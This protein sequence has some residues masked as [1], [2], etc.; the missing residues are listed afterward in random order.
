MKKKLKF[1]LTMCFAIFLFSILTVSASAESTPYEPNRTSS[2]RYLYSSSDCDRTITVNCYDRDTGT[3]IKVVNLRTK[4]SE[5]TLA[6]VRIYGYRLT[7][8]SSDQGLWETCK[9]GNSQGLQI[10]GEI[11]IKYYF[12]TAMS[13]EKLT[14]T[15]YMDKF[16][17]LTLT[18]QHKKQE[19]Y[20]ANL[21]YASYP[22]TYSR[23]ITTNTGRYVSMGGAYTGFTIRSGWE[24]YVAGNFSYK[25][26][27]DYK[28]I[29]SPISSM[30]WRVVGATCDTGAFYNEFNENE[31]GHYSYCDNRTMVC[32]FEYLRNKYTVSFSANGGTG[33]VPSS[34]TQY[35]GYTVT[36]GT[37]VP[38]RDGY[39]FKGWSTS[40]SATAASY[41]PGGIYTMGVT[42]TLYAVWEKY[43]YEFSISDLTVTL[44][45]ELFP[46]TTIPIRVRTDSW[47]KNDSYDDVPVELYYDGKLLSTQYID[48]APFQI[49]Y[50][51]FNLNVG[52]STGSHTIEI[53]INWNKKSAETNP[54]NN[55]VKTEI[56]I[57][58][59]SYGF[60]IQAL[61][62]SARYKEGT[63]VMTSFIVYN[64]SERMVLPD[65]NASAEFIVYYYDGNEKVLLTNQVWYDIVIPA[66]ESNLI[67]FR[68]TVPEDF[69]GKNVVCQC[70]INL[71]GRLKEGN[72]LDNVVT[73]TTVIADRGYSQTSN[74]SYEAKAPGDYYQATAPSI[75]NG[76]ASWSL[77]EYTN[78]E[79]VKVQYG[80]KISGDTPS[81]QP[82]STCETAIYENGSWT[83]KSGY[84]ITLTYAPTITSLSGSQMPSSSDYTGI[85]TVYAT[86]PE[87]CYSTDPEEFRSLESVGGVW[88]FEENI[89]ADGNERLHYIPVWMEDG[90]YRVSVTV[91]D[92]WTPAGLVMSVRNSEIIVVDGTIFD[93][94]YIGI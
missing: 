8:F 11:Y 58:S 56:N 34:Q 52:S 42:P 61:T 46:N 60:E 47:D 85:Q 75:K 20:G 67:F 1:L 17:D 83:M 28:N 5:D 22:V 86:F 77:W 37:T 92:V 45:D 21:S 62:G 19:P 26:V 14:V 41:Q 36:I 78:G 57:I 2:T 71:D 39:I 4:K 6:I 16:N 29:E 44:P 93:D 54:N 90:Q 50:I 74:P 43:D 18:E 64:H 89:S 91:T 70:S 35:Y 81:V 66:S 25:W 87:Y 23:N 15:V 88:R 10:Y 12:R 76:S 80:I 82:G 48:F 63:D 59:D 9:L 7:S 38:T 79:F 33:S 24:Q 31:D 84:G 30:T 27:D 72:L 68:W 53:R 32:D 13:K 49:I 65:V 40:S 55:S 73:L 69:A 51:N 94:Y 3:L